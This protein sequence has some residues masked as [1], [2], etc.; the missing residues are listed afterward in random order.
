[1]AVEDDASWV[2]DV[3]AD[4]LCCSYV[5]QFVQ[6][7]VGAYNVKAF[8]FIPFQVCLHPSGRNDPGSVLPN[9]RPKIFMGPMGC[10]SIAIL[11]T[12]SW[13]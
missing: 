3:H 1:M 7:P 8:G 2:F 12:V 4:P 6:F 13:T 5:S 10:L 9:V 11:W